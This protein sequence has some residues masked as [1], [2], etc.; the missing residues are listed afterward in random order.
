MLR[1]VDTHAAAHVGGVATRTGG[2]LQLARLALGLLLGSADDER[3]P[4]EEEHVLRIAPGS[5]GARAH[6]IDVAAHGLD[7]RGR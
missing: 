3:E 6:V 4:L 5:R 7:V 2:L 1:E